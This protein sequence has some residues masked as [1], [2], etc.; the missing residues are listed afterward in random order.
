MREVNMPDTLTNRAYD[1]FSKREA[2]RFLMQEL[3]NQTTA[4]QKEVASIW[5]G[6][7][8]ESKKQGITRNG[9]EVFHFDYVEKKFA[10]INKGEVI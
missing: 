2:L 5:V 1:A 4:N 3:V 7:D 10:I 9:D 6:V 8:V